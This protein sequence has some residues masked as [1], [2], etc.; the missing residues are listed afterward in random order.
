MP[1][2]RFC[3]KVKRSLP[4]APDD[5][6]MTKGVQRLTHP[7]TAVK[8]IQ[9][10]FCKYNN[11]IGVELRKV[12]SPVLIRLASEFRTPGPASGVSVS[13][14]YGVM[15]S[16]T[17]QLLRLPTLLVDDFD[18]V[19]PE[20]LRVTYVEALY[21]AD[22][23][24]FEASGGPS[25]PSGGPSGGAGRPTAAERAPTAAERVRVSLQRSSSACLL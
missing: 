21:R 8:T 10:R 6:P 4:F 22:D 12:G 9:Y 2:R 15:F 25:C 13:V 1:Q 20:L 14:K 19:A 16:V 23:F 7:A 24:E 18:E 3:R 5:R 11:V 17:L